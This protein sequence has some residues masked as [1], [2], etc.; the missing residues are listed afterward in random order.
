MSI[1][2]TLPHADAPQV[3]AVRLLPKGLLA[4]RK[5][6]PWIFED[7]LSK[8]PDGARPGD[9]AVLF[10]DRKKLGAGI[11]DPFS[12]IRIRVLA[13][14]A[15]A[16]EVGSALF[17]EL[18]AK[19]A[20]RRAGLFGPETNAYRLVNGESDGFSGLMADR[21]A[22]VLAL[23][24]YTAAWLPYLGNVTD[25]LCAANPGL[26]RLAVRFSREVSA[27]PPEIR[28]HL[29]DGTLF[30]PPD[31]DGRVLFLENSLKFEADVKAGQKTGFF[32][33]QRE[34]RAKVGELAKGM[35]KVLNV[36]SYSGG[37]SLYAARSGAEEVTDIDFSKQA[38]AASVRNFELNQN[39]PGVAS[40]RHRGIADDAFHAMKALEEKGELFELVIVDPPSFAKSSAERANALNSYTRLASLAVRLLRKNGILVFASCSSRIV[41]DELF[42][43]VHK[44][45]RNAG[46][47]LQ[48]FERRAEAPDHP[49]DFRES[50][51]L[52]CLYA[53]V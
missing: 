50:H 5:K 29:E 34:N 39:F 19:A 3:K 7:S 14:G 12:E 32:L 30:G 37:F 9:I 8:T 1:N 38:I 16:P 17:E 36:F 51:Y 31:W 10:D 23:K 4:V 21:Y 40:C 25:A 45:A 33:D 13:W 20:L 43:E 2:H 52:K 26:T 48:E 18:A 42:E 46:R 15:K 27:L 6:H 22:D 24:V 44:A 49:A 11:L 47:P 28:F 41:A 35:K 53:R